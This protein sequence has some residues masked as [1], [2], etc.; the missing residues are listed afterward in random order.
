M[1]SCFLVAFCRVS[2][3]FSGVQFL[4]SI[5]WSPFSRVHFLE[6]IFWSLFSGV[7][8]LEVIFWSPVSGIR[9]LEYIFWNPFSG[10]HFLVLFR[11]PQEPHALVDPCRGSA[12]VLCVV[13]GDGY[14]YIY[15]YSST[16]RFWGD[17]FLLSLDPS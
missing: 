12:C 8:F 2:V 16:F 9:F 11:C 17:V 13:C 10:V 6:S 5:F 7:H 1:L 14:I 15:V 4:E 3:Q